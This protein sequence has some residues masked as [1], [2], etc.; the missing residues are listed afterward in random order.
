M[1]DCG[2]VKARGYNAR[3]GADS[4]QVGRG[5]VLFV[6]DCGLVKARGYNTLL[7]AGW[8]QVGG[9]GQG[10]RALGFKTPETRTHAWSGVRQPTG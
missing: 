2:L 9:G 10:V 7:G 4:L 6:L 3:L 5:G 1:L 8:L